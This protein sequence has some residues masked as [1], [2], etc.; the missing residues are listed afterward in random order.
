MAKYE[1]LILSPSHGLLVS[2]E[3]YLNDHA[4]VRAGM[5]KGQGSPV[6][7]WRGL[8]CVYGASSSLRP[9]QSLLPNRA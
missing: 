7:I 6:E 3:V 1:I 8:Q 9:P 4:A 5:R 2:E